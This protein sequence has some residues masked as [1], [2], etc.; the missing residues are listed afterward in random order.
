ML[1]DRLEEFKLGCSQASE[2][3]IFPV[4]ARLQMQDNEDLILAEAV[5]CT[6]RDRADSS[7]HQNPKTGTSSASLANTQDIRNVLVAL[8]EV[9]PETPRNMYDSVKRRNTGKKKK[10]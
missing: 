2:V 10:L 5:G 1:S 4:K 6:S 3:F 7:E 9:N 8:G